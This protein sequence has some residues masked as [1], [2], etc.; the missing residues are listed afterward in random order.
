MTASP[1]PA[2]PRVAGV[3]MIRNECDIIELFLTINLRELDYIYLLDHQ[4]D[5]GT[6]AIIEAL[7]GDCPNISYTYWPD[8]E[9]R[10]AAAVTSAVREIAAKGIFDYLVPLDADEFLVSTV[11]GLS[12]RETLAATL[13]TDRFGLVPWRTYCP[14]SADYFGT[15]AP[16]HDVFRPRRVENPQFHK[17]V[18]GNEY[19]RQCSI[20]EG[21]HL[22]G[23][24]TYTTPPQALPL[25]LQH[26][27][28]RS[29]EQIIR[30][31]V[32]GHHTLRLKPARGQ[33]EGTH[34]DD[35]AALIRARGFKLDDATLTSLAL[36]YA[37]APAALTENAVDHAA[38]GIG[39]PTD[40]LRFPDLAR[41]NVL[42]HFDAYITQLVD[43]LRNLPA[44]QA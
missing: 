11:P 3:A 22:A 43:R 8:K 32:L 6:R 31:A 10:Q 15:R 30:K 9:F 40:A 7:Q 27:P 24:E 5:D 35:M 16:L 29:P 25:V 1:P 2:Q 36:A 38:P 18:L 21:N 41:P 12:V 14:V 26:A 33:A 19:A 13:P 39:L 37:A 20:G 17:V 44:A 23:H 42:A 34:W 4:S 28:V